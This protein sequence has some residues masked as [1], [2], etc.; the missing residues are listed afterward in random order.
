MRCLEGRQPAER[1]A[2]NVVRA[3]SPAD[4][5]R[6]CLLF[7]ERNEPAR[8]ARHESHSV[9]RCGGAAPPARPRHRRRDRAR[10]SIIASSCMGPEVAEFEAKLAAFCGA[11]A[12]A[13]LR[14]RHRRAGAGADGEGD[15]PGRRGDSARPS[16]S[17][18]RPRWSALLGA[19]PVFVDVD[20]DT[21][22]HRCRRA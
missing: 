16:P 18:R 7:R 13:V 9:H 3:A 14:Q 1:R 10:H 17:A 5:F 11:Q 22:Q 20:A 15:R 6:S 4:C 8:P 21:L 19:T 12:C 2:A